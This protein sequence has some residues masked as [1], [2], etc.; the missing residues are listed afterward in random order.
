MKI[1][2]S[3]L[4]S[5][6]L[7]SCDVA[8]T[9]IS[10]P[11]S[12]LQP[13]C[14]VRDFGAR[15]DGIADDT[16][17]I[18]TAI[19]SCSGT[20]IFPTG[21]YLIKEGLIVNADNLTLK[22]EG[23]NTASQLVCASIFDVIT[24][25]GSRCTVDGLAVDGNKISKNGIIINGTQNEVQ[26]CIVQNCGANGIVSTYPSHNKNI[27]NCKVFTCKYSA[28]ISEASDASI[29]DC[30]IANNEGNQQIILA[31]SNNRIFNCH[32]WSGDQFVPNPN[33]VG[34][35]IRTSG[36]QVQGCA[37]DRN[38]SFG[39]SINPNDQQSVNGGIITGNW[40]YQNGGTIFLSP[41]A[42]GIIESQNSYN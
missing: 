13:T 17:S 24:I 18:Q 6:F 19:N 21:N 23:K 28:I 35:E 11:K 36:C 20:V 10:L 41:K 32:I 5:L 29:S 31:G 16:K 27:K 22:G 1:L 42:T 7:A 25:N 33:T 37:L 26:N 3:L 8:D 39:I 38:N 15:G 34:V 9:I 12:E 14:N 30:E 4:L 2:I 40:F